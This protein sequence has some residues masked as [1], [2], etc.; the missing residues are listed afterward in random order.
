MRTGIALILA[1]LAAPVTAAEP[2]TLIVNRVKM[3][4]L[5][6]VA[7]IPWQG[8][9]MKA[10]AM[11]VYCAEGGF[12]FGMLGQDVVGLNGYSAGFREGGKVRFASGPLRPITTTD[13]RDLVAIGAITTAA[14]PLVYNEVASQGLQ[15]GRKACP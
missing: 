3:I 5:K 2:P 1:A 14:E 11:S 13:K 4:P 7:D 10:Q 9:H 12:V 15:A 6:H 8:E